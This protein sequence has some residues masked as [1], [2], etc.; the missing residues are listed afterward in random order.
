MTDD[1]PNAGDLTGKRILL[2]VTGSIAAYKAADIASRLRHHGADVTA[3]LTT[4][5][6]A[7]IGEA[8]LRALT[9]N[10]VLRGVFDEPYAHRIA[11]IEAAQMADVF[12]VAPAT[13]NI[14]AKMAH[15][16]ADNMLS[17]LLLATTAPIIVA[18]AMNSVMLDH[19]ATRENLSTLRN[20]DVHIIDTQ[21]GEL[22]CRAE[23]FGKLADVDDIVAAVSSLLHTTTDLAGVKV[24]VTAGATR[25]PLDPV[26]FLSN[27]SSGKMGVA[28]A[29]AARDRGAQVTLVAGHVTVD[30]PA[31]VTVV[32]AG[33]TRE[34]L[35]ACRQPFATC[36]VFISAAA[37]A[38]FEAAEIALNKIKKGSEE[39]VSIRLRKTPDVI[40]SLTE[41]RQQQVVVGFAAETEDLIGHAREK[42]ARKCLD[43]I[44][45][46]DVTAADAGFETDTNRVTLLW[47]DG[48]TQEIP[49]LT[50]HQ[51]ADHILDATRDLLAVRR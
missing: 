17:T 44:A 15:G 51:V 22:A 21:Y 40:A 24:V 25:E 27:R 23:G 46:N 26:R 13:A 10:P 5:A 43:L 39:H 37:P 49:L 48:R 31:G 32:R 8:T 45:A 42:I 33:T 35:E 34:L 19:P 41:H 29:E 11:H 47:P 9:G 28:I 36:D 38:D 16:I 18:P 2:G 7:F 4:H 1:P 14:L 6:E 20:R 12:L 30:L 3:V 50:K